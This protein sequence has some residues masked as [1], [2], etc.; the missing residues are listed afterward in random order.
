MTFLTR[1]GIGTVGFLALSVMLLANGCGSGS[2]NCSSSDWNTCISAHSMECCAAESLAFCDWDKCLS[3]YSN[4][5]CADLVSGDFLSCEVSLLGYACPEGYFC[6][7]TCS[8]FSDCV[9]NAAFTCPAGYVCAS[10]N[11]QSLNDCTAVQG[12]SCP[13]GYYCASGN[14]Q[15]L[16][17]CTLNSTQPVVCPEGTYCL[18]HL[19]DC[20]DLSGCIPN[21]QCPDGY[22]CTPGST[23]D[24][25]AKCII[26]STCQIGYYCPADKSPCTNGVGCVQKAD[27]PIKSGSKATLV[28]V[29][30]G[31]T[32]WVKISGDNCNAKK[33]D[34]RLHGIDSP[35]CTKDRQPNF[36]YSCIK[37]TSYGNDNEPW[38]YES[39]KGLSDI[40]AGNPELTITCEEF[41]KDGSC[42]F[43]ATDNRRLAYI[44]L[45]Y[46]GKYIDLATESARQGLSFARTDFNS[47]KLGSIC[48]AEFKDAV[49]NS[50]GMWSQGTYDQVINSM[51]S[52]KKKWL[53]KH[54]TVCNNKM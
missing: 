54:K 3:D 33:Y 53:K 8:S 48:S 50:S 13:A 35:E 41:E 28:N 37:S 10:G 31:D 27:C 25:G 6:P 46:N 51:G 23:C 42:G 32:I 2:E 38:G 1:R 14:C 21:A 19:M 9:Q 12:F 5:I 44:G 45:T 4:K 11:C 20:S 49:V 16:S 7:G 29:T 30:D 17:D 34:I 22:Y 52:T 36:Y 47:S 40:L 18:S 26:S 15:S 24:K 43:D 39:W